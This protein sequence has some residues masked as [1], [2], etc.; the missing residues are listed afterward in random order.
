MCLSFAFY[1]SV[2]ANKSNS[3]PCDVDL[4]HLGIKKVLLG[5]LYMR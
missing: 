5:L 4:P 2:P 3:H 1:T